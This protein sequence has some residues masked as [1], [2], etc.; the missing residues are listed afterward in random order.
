MAYVDLNPIRVKIANTSETSEHT[1]I[2]QRLNPLNN[3]AAYSLMPIVGNSRQDMPK[4]IAFLLKDCCELV[5]ITDRIIRDD[6]AGH[7]D[8][9]QQSILQRAYQTSNGS[10]LPRSLK[11]TFVMQRVLK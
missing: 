10:P 5:N 8:H 9:Q 4:G 3:F 1:S 6:K 2:V 7:I 11:N